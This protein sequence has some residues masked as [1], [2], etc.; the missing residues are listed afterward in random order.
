[1]KRIG[2]VLARAVGTP[3]AFVVRWLLRLSG[4]KAGI[5]LVYHAIDEQAGDPDLELVPA[6]ASSVFE[7]H[8][9]YLSRH[10]RIVR[11][12]E[13]LA[14][15]SERRRGERY[16]VAITFDDDLRCHVAVALPI[17][18][19]VG[20]PATFFLTGAS[21][22]RPFS[23]WWERLERAFDQG[24][25]D[26]AEL[27]S[28]AYRGTQPSVLELG[29]VVQQ[30]GSEARATVDARLA[31]VAGADP[32]DAG[33]R[34][35]D[36]RR[37]LRARMEI[38]FHT[39]RH[40]NLTMLTDDELASAME[41]GLEALER[42]AEVPVQIICY[43]YGRADERVANAARAAR[44]LAGFTTR[45]AAV[46]PGDDPLLNGR[47]GPSNLPGVFAAQLVVALL[48]RSK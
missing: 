20:V 1:M 34:A 19:R 6:T 38:G 12:G 7:G 40:D 43:P 35:A 44:F 17:L 37:L 9:R 3:V 18:E 14:A 28:A 29:M 32:P 42:V 26:V 47:I 41:E 22:E 16:P 31:E 10:Y 11:A 21:L 27:M 8:L 30:L 36:V 45:R 23:F 25:P 2:R 48:R 39:L 15:V 13:L 33:L 46:R 5:A 4:Q 24:V